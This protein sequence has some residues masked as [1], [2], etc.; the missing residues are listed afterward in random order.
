MLQLQDVGVVLLLVFMEG[1]LSAD[2][3]IVLAVLALPLPQEDQKK[4]FTIRNVGRVWIPYNRCASCRSTTK[5][6]LDEVVWRNV[7]S[8]SRNKTFP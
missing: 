7:F 5:N 6:S 4:S 3:A 1:L 2:N 8:L